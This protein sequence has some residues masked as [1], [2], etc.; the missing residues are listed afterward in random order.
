LDWPEVDHVDL[1]NVP[2]M[3]RDVG[4]RTA[5]LVVTWTGVRVWVD[6]DRVRKVAEDGMWPAVVGS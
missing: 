6:T 3:T 2:S 4:H 5:K 1:A